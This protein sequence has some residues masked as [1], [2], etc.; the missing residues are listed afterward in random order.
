M[1]FQGRKLYLI[2]PTSNMMSELSSARCADAGLNTNHLR[3]SAA[4]H[5][6]A[7]GKKVLASLEFRTATAMRRCKDI[8]CQRSLSRGSLRVGPGLSLGA[9]RTEKPPAAGHAIFMALDNHNIVC[10]MANVLRLHAKQLLG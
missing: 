6:L 4:R 1:L 9:R 8:L 7:I 10:I 3:F 5:S 2:G